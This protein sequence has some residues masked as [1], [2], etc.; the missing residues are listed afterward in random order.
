MR[1]SRWIVFVLAMVASC[2][3]LAQTDSHPVVSG[4]EV[5]IVSLAKPIF[6]PL[7][8]QARIVGEVELKLGIRLDGSVESAVA[9]SGHPMLIQAALNSAQQSRFECR[10][11]ENEVTSYSLVYSF[12]FSAVPPRDWPCPERNEPVVTQ[13]GH[14]VT[15]TAEPALVHPYFGYVSARSAKCAYLWRCGWQ[16]GGKDYY[17]YRVRSAKCLGLWNCGHRLREPFATC[18]RLHRKLLY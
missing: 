18:Q 14:Q 13:S 3:A 4:G 11:C 5:V 8:R 7:A 16:W 9:V 10:S 17:F 1:H 6:P 2:A 12:Q 15:V